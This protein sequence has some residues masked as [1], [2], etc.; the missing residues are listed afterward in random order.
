MLGALGHT[1]PFLERGRHPIAI[2]SLVQRAFEQH[3]GRLLA[4]ISQVRSTSPEVVPKPAKH[5]SNSKTGRTRPNLD[6]IGANLL[7]IIPNAIDLRE[8]S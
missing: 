4:N 8:L 3:A 2:R 7:D 1:S 6:G 5:G